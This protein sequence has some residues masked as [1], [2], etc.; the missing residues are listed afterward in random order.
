[1]LGYITVFTF[2]FL[3]M[4]HPAHAYIDAGTGS[5]I[6]QVLLGGAVGLIAFIKIYWQQT[7]TFFA[8]VFSGK[9]EACEE[10]TAQET[11]DKEQ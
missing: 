3:M 9:G 7:K 1:M 6:I 2:V 11:T 5:L 8:R 10:L 4:I